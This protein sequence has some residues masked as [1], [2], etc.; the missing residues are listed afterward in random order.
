MLP[1]DTRKPIACLNL[2]PT[3]RFL[4]FMLF[5]AQRRTIL[6]VDHES[7]PYGEINL[8]DLEGGI[9]RIKGLIRRL[10]DRNQVPAN[11]LTVMV[12]P[13]FFTRDANYPD[14]VDA[15]ELQMLMLSQAESFYLFKKVE[16]VVGVAP[17]F[18]RGRLIYSAY[19]KLNYLQLEQQFVDLKIPLIAVESHPIATIRGVIASGFVQEEIANELTWVFFTVTD[20]SVFMSLML[21]S[22]L[23]RI[24]ESPI[25]LQGGDI[26]GALTQLNEDYMQF[27]EYEVVNKVIVVNNSRELLSSQLRETIQHETI[28]LFDQNESTLESLGGKEAQA[29]CSFEIL[30]AG[31][32]IVD[33]MVP[34]VN[35]LQRNI[36]DLTVIQ[37]QKDKVAMG[38]IAAGMTLFLVYLA[39]NS[40]FG[41]LATQETAKAEEIQAKIQQLKPPKETFN[42]LK[43]QMFVQRAYNQNIRFNNLMITLFQALPPDAWLDQVDFESQ[44]DFRSYN[45]QVKGAT[46]SPDP[47]NTY[48]QELGRQLMGQSLSPMVQPL[49][50]YNQ[51]QYF[52]FELKTQSPT[53]GQA[54]GGVR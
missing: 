23:Q 2:S 37:R 17:L 50:T 35:L 43:Q 18:E 9:D 11:A 41:F 10:L 20:T 12:V 28:V 26:E 15:S 16:P 3:G 54:T 45:I 52:G 1:Y 38:L 49:Q 4:E 36:F 48:I 33:N 13:S 32:A 40:L 44:A 51:Q 25:T 53:A 31:M 29:P 14:G 47:L 8:A 39:I 27:C 30:G 42:K 6:K 34:V 21:G 19:P 24:M 5:D 22:N 7:F 46:L